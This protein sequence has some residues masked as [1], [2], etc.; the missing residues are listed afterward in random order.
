[1]SACRNAFGQFTACGSRRGSLSGFGTKPRKS[2]LKVQ[3]DLAERLDAL[4]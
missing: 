3:V 1:M 4:R 2:A